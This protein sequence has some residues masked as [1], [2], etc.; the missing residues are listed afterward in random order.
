M[1]APTEAG[2]LQGY[3]VAQHGAKEHCHVSGLRGLNSTYAL[4]EVTKL[5]SEAGPH[6]KPSR[7]PPQCSLHLI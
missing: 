6:K 1:E 5:P 4:L 2:C 7:F 3:R